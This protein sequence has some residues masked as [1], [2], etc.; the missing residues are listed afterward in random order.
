MTKI[1]LVGACGRMGRMVAQC[2]QEMP[3]AEIVAGVDTVSPDAPLPFPLYKSLDEITEHVDVVMDFS[4]AKTLESVLEFCVE[5]NVPAVLAATGY[6]PEQKA[7]IRHATMNIPIFQSSNYSIGV[8]LVQEMARQ[9]A[10]VMRDCDIEI[11]EKH[12]SGKADA[13]S[14]TALTLAD[15][16]ADVLAGDVEYVFGRHG[17]GTQRKP[18]EIGIH[19]VRGGALVG[20]HEVLFLSEEEEVDLVH[21]AYSRKVFANGALAAALSITGKSPS[22]YGMADLLKNLAIVPRSF[23]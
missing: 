17:Q 6:T 13:P 10:A 21:K 14:G 5:R 20:E 4:S 8:C 7:S 11:I 3:A 12:H 23:V 9:V 22:L 15:T 16:I 1:A 2:A 18:N 19:A